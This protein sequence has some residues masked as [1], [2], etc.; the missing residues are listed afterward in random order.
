[1]SKYTAAERAL[2]RSIIA[3]LSIKRVPEPQII[4]EVFRQTNKTLSHSG[5]YRIKQAI[6]RESYNWFKEMRSGQ[7]EYIHE[8][9]ERISEIMDLQKRHHAILDSATEPTTVKQASLIELHK[10]SITLS[11]LYDVAPAIVGNNGAV[12]VSAPSESNKASDTT[13]RTKEYIV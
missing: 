1:V 8:F 10:L 3:S 4:E 9:K 13:T 11:N 12:T 2:I 7:F 6:K 5:L